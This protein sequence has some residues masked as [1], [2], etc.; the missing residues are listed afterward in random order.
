MKISFEKKDIEKILQDLATENGKFNK[1]YPGE[2]ADRQPLHTVYGGAN[3]FKSTLAA[4][5]GDLGK[6]ALNAYAPD[7]AT[8]ACALQFPGFER[9]PKG[10]SEIEALAKEIENDKEAFEK[11]DKDIYLAYIVYQRVLEKLSREA[12]EDFRIDF[13]DGFGNRPDDE[14]DATAVQA[15]QQVAEGMKNNTLPPFIGIRIKPFTEELKARGIRTLDIFLTT[16]SELTDGKLPDNFLVT[17]PKVTIAPQVAALVDLFE[18][19]ENK[20]KIASGTLKVE[21]MIETTQSIYDWSGDIVIPKL[22]D[23]ARGRCRGAHFGTYDYTATCNI[24]ATYQAMRHPSCDFAKD[25]MQVSLAG[26]GVWLSDGATTT[27]PIGPH[28]A[29]KGG[30]DLSDEQKAENEKVVFSAWKLAYDNVMHSLK[31]GYYQGWDLNPGQ[32]PIR[33]AANYLFF[34]S[35]LNDVSVRLSNFIGKA[36][37][38][39]LSGN[40][41]DDAATGQGLLNYFLRALSI[42]AVSMNEVE[43]TGLTLEEI[44]SK[45]FKVIVD[46]RS[47]K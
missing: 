11:K 25:V 22:V 2:S 8:L 21:L 33:Y 20:T 30:P 10:K 26:T 27:M 43:K 44:K 42:G 18:I 17:L 6:R 7:F 13:E 16:L 36:A 32:L 38:A 24:T 37:Q 5:F 19:I 46:N 28:R 23:A 35:S 41:F 34:L 1:I 45:S 12:V 15:A 40:E 31:N 3:L 29:A 14:E 4:K 39:T 9:L 47:K